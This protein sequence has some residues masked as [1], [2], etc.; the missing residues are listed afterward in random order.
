MLFLSIE[1]QVRHYFPSVYQIQ[2]HSLLVSTVVIEKSV[3]RILKENK[4]FGGLI[5]HN[6]KPTYKATVFQTVQYWPNK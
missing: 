1:F 4:K 3:C 5:P 2:F 6:L